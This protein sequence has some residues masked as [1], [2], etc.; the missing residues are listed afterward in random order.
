MR[1][2]ANRWNEM[3]PVISSGAPEEV[4]IR[5]DISHLVSCPRPA[6]TF[7]VIFF[8]LH[9]FARMIPII[10]HLP[11]TVFCLSL[12]SPLL[13]FNPLLRHA[14]VAQNHFF[15]ELDKRIGTAS[16]KNCVRQIADVLLYPFRRDA[17]AAACP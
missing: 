9:R 11:A 10:S 1:S 7:S 5:S 8:L 4:E 12:S 17:P 2:R 14:E 13:R 3:V 16:V 6:W 15:G